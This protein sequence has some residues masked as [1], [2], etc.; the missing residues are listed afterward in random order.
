MRCKAIVATISK[1]KITLDIYQDFANFNK[2]YTIKNSGLYTNRKG[3]KK[4]LL[5]Y[6][7]CKKG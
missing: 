1:K 3:E 5:Y 2:V 4:I 7:S 6:F